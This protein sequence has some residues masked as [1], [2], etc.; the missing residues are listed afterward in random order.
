MK[1]TKRMIALLI[2]LVMVMSM[3]MSAFAAA[4]ATDPYDQPLTITNLEEGDTV[5]FYQII[6]WDPDDATSI[7]G[8]VPIAPLTRDQ[9]KEIIGFVGTPGDPNANP[10][11]PAE[12][13]VT[14]KGITSEL[15]GVLARN[16]TSAAFVTKIVGQGETAVVMENDQPGMWM[17]LIS[18][19]N[20]DVVYNPVFI[21]SDFEKSKPGD[22]A[23][24]EKPTYSNKSAAKKSTVTL[25][26]IAN[27]NALTWATTAIGEQV[28]F[29]ATT[30][31]PGY[32]AA[33][34]K[35]F[36]QITDVLT[37]LTLI[38]D[39][40]VVTVANATAGTDYTVTTAADGYVVLFAEDFL[41]KVTQ[42]T[43]VKVEYSA[44]VS[45]DADYNVNLERNEISTEFSNNPRSTTDHGFK[46]DET[47]HFT[48][49]IDA[50]SLGFDGKQEGKWTAEIVK[51][52]RN[53]DGTPVTDVKVDSKIDPA[54]YW[55]SPLA[56]C[57]FKL[58]TDPDCTKEYQPKDKDGNNITP[59][60]TYTSD[61]NGRITI[62]GLDAGVYYLLETAAP[63]GYIKDP[64]AHKVEIV[65]HIIEDVNP[66]TK[67]TTDGVKWYPVATGAAGEQGYTFYTDE[68]TGY[69]VYFDDDLASSYTVVNPGE[70][71]IDWD[72]EA[73]K[74]LPHNIVNT[75]GVE[76]P[77]TGGIGTTL[78]YVVG[79][80]LVIGAAVLLVSK[81]R[82]SN[83]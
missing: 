6:K 20:P 33:Y 48:F 59:I 70:F 26:K 18:P 71:E 8:W 45:T 80:V 35:P 16:S 68:L 69:E 73:P 51:V 58:F 19:S 60:P 82:M 7:G 28:D 52:G 44:I 29:T 49:T 10:P 11:V 72:I 24:D 36:F 37:D 22:V 17:A 2:A 62:K 66:Q 41:K 30:K 4:P 67:Y 43:D 38:E 77:S 34:E 64:N 63:A 32:G 61:A 13:A 81:R 27:G 55:E 75:L 14:A 21:A 53:A 31:I 39:S 25:E 65:A 57:E 46:H 54:Q 23:I 79:S 9:L 76:L 12:P 15:A 50:N 1:K 83:R 40:V 56:D 3:S 78:F 47:N 5:D 74:E 42:P